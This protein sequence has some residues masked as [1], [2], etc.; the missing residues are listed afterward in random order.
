LAKPG[1]NRLVI[2]SHLVG[3]I[4]GCECGAVTAQV[5]AHG[6]EPAGAAAPSVI[7]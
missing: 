3:V 7:P 6:L 5:P 1:G 2:S 4:A